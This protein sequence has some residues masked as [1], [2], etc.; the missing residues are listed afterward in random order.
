MAESVKDNIVAKALRCIDEVYPAENALNESFYATDDFIGEAV[1]W[2]IDNVPVHVFPVLDATQVEFARSEYNE[3]YGYGV[4]SEELNG[5]IIF[6]KDI[7]WKRPVLD[8][9]YDTDVRY[10]QQQNRVLR[11]NN[12]HPVAVIARGSSALEW[13]PATIDSF[14]IQTIDGE[15]VYK[16]K[17]EVYKA[18]YDTEYI[19]SHLIDITAWK[20]AEIVLTSMHD[21]Q[22]AS[23]C[24]AKVN[25]HLSQL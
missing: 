6:V 7:K 17:I 12:S 23:I 24:T 15:T 22:S 19:P 9:I 16:P 18:P 2:V 13:Y 3:G 11:G 21:I 4:L 8:I 25:E 1:R 20:L 14:D 10:R 5:R